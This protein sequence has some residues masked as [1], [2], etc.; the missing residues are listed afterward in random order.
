[1]TV[2]IAWIVSPDSPNVRLEAA[3]KSRFEVHVF[4]RGID[5]YTWM[6]SGFIPHVVITDEKLPDIDVRELISRFKNSSYY[7]DIPFIVLPLST[8]NARVDALL[9]SGA[10]DSVPFPVDEEILFLSIRNLL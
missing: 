7:C 4:H 10:E 8:Q 6:H 2:K 9:A 1:M 3:L 5:A